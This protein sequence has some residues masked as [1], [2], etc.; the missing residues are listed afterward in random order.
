MSTVTRAEFAR[1]MQ[2]QRSTVTRW[3]GAGRISVDEHDRIDADMARR[4]LGITAS[5][6]PHHMAR[7]DQLAEQRQQ[8]LPLPPATD[9]DN[10]GDH[11]ELGDRLAVDR[12]LKLAR[13]MREESEA[14]MAAMKRDE[15]AKLLVQRADVDFVMADIGRT[16]GDLL[17]RM[18]DQYTPALVSAA[19]DANAIHA[20]LR[21][22]GRDLRAEL[23]NHMRRRAEDLL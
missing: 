8:Q 22:A 19:S 10:S 11:S 13:A 4:Q 23:A 21:E 7:S 5:P 2:V 16:I 18:A 17:D 1:I 3:I 12:R 15:Q 9:R 6:M 20:V 14:Q